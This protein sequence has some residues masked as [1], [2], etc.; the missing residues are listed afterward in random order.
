MI[1]LA[2]VDLISFYKKAEEA[3]VDAVFGNRFVKGGRV[4]GYPFLKLMPL[5]ELL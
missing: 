3:K 4:I 2:P 5:L 1:Y